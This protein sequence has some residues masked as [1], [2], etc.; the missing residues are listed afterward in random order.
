MAAGVFIR[1]FFNLRHKGRVEWR[2]PVIGVLLLVGVAVAIAPKA[3]VAVAAAPVV[4]QAAQFK[5]VQAI[6]AQR[7]ATCHSAKPTQAGFATAPAGMML[8]NET[9]IRQHAAQIYKQAIELK[10]MPIGN[11]T[12]MTDAERSELGAWLQQT[13]QGTK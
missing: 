2:Y 3:P 8:D 13:L 10:A 7:C 5:S 1:H 6:I 4:D 9:E 11:L 12:N